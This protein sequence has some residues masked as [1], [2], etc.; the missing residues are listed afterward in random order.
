MS[1]DKMQLERAQPFFKWDLNTAILVFGFGITWGVLKTNVN[2][3][4][5]DQI[6][7]EASVAALLVRVVA[8]ESDIRDEKSWRVGHESTNK[9]R[10]GEIEGAIASL[11]TQVKTQDE[12]LDDVGGLQ[13]R[14]ADQQ[15]ATGA[16]LREVQDDIRTVQGDL[17]ELKS[18]Q[19]LILSYINE[20]R[21]ANNTTLQREFVR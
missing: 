9:D 2:D 8:N 18:D 3:I 7:V 11:G 21:E 12:R 16:T 10:R 1:E 5:S 20:Q 17:A 6:K 19:K 4:A 13:A 14:Q 15:S